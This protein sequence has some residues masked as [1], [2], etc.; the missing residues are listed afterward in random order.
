MTT[1]QEEVIV[2]V[3]VS[4]KVETVDGK[5]LPE[6][7]ITPL[8][9]LA[10]NARRSQ[11]DRMRGEKEHELLTPSRKGRTEGERKKKSRVKRH[12][13]QDQEERT[14]SPLDLRM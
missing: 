2:R 7:K 5:Q 13:N 11:S 9:S 14:R 3:R 1:L 10:H 12:Q 6:E 8:S 4:R